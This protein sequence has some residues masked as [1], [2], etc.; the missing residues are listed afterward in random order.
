MPDEKSG[1]EL[2]SDFIRSGKHRT[3]PIPAEIREKVQVWLD[4]ARAVSRATYQEPMLPPWLYRPDI[5]AYSIGWRMGPGEDYW[6]DF[7]SW[8]V[9]LSQADRSAY[10]ETHQEPPDWEGFYARL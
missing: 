9:A 4:D 2:L 6:I 7:R 3:E 8:F 1:M 5:P 10:V